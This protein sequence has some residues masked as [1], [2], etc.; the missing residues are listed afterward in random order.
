[1]VIENNAQLDVQNLLVPFRGPSSSQGELQKR[2]SKVRR[3]PLPRSHLKND[4]LL[5]H[6]G[7]LQLGS[8]R[9]K[10]LRDLLNILV[11]VFAR[12]RKG[13]NGTINCSEFPG[14]GRERGPLILAQCSSWWE[15][16]EYATKG[17]SRCEYYGVMEVAGMSN[18][19][20]A[21]P[22]ATRTRRLC[23]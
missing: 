5:Q 8:D 20:A 19:A 13:Y 16:R 1:M 4:V 23:K 17:R 7:P 3:S 9:N 21:T 22:T 11:G 14:R 6:Q 10:T 18:K 12:V 15:K 2:S